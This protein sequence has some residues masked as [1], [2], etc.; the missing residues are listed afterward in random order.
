[1]DT[2]TKYYLKIRKALYNY[3]DERTVALNGFYKQIRYNYFKEEFYV[4]DK[5]GHTKCL[6][7]LTSDELEDILKQVSEA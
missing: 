7:S 5:F 2:A 6:V 1:M 3:K 4:T